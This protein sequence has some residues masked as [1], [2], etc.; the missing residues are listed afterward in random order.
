M[1]GLAIL[2]LSLFIIS[3]SSGEKIDVKQEKT[4]INKKE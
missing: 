4:I 1:K 2:I 3:C